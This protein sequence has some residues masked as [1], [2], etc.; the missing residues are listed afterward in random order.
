M[1][2]LISGPLRTPEDVMNNDL[3]A[4]L[5][6]LNNEEQ[7]PTALLGRLLA[8]EDPAALGE[9]WTHYLGRLRRVVRAK[10]Q[11]GAR[12]FD[13]DDVLEEAF[14][15]VF[16]REGYLNKY[17]DR[18]RARL[19]PCVLVWLR[20]AALEALS[21]LRRWNHTAGRNPH[22]EVGLSAE[23]SMHLAALVGRGP[24]PSSAAGHAEV[25]ERVRKVLAGLSQDDRDVLTL[26]FIE[27]LSHREVADV[28][29]LN[30][31]AA[32]K[33]SLRAQKRFRDGWNSEFGTGEV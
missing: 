14:Q 12:R 33:R 15:I 5:T 9:L 13:E 24:S 11:E 8:G 30:Y 4:Y 26:N 18:V 17:L 29:E 28:V 22:V 19:G 6:E 1:G 21:K 3:T 16:A 31:D 2:N 7:V 10:L 32:V 27:G 25:P 23:G 20:G